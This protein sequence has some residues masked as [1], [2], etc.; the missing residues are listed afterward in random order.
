MRDALLIIHILAIAAWIG[1]S[2]MNGVINM[3]VA[4][5]GSVEGNAVLARSTVKLGMVFYMPAAIVTLLSGIGLIIAS[6]DAYSWGAPWV[7][8][9]FLAV[10]VAAILG[11]VKFLPLSE[12]IAAGYEAGDVEA[13]QK[14]SKDIAMWSSVNTLILVVALALMVIKPG[15]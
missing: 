12:Q 7:S 3:R 2:I 14:A 10:I 13:A 8:F 9:G 11:P 15:S 6:D 5:A 4:A 1:G